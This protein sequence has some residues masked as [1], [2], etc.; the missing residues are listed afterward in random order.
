[1]GLDYR[2]TCLDIDGSIQDYKDCIKQFLENII[3]QCS[4]LI[5]EAEKK[6]L[7]EDYLDDFYKEFESSFEGIRETNEDM[8]KEAD[9]QIGT[10]EEEIL[11]LKCTVDEMNYTIRGLEQKISELEAYES[12][13]NR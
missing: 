12:N 13:F 5:G 6:D 1:M 4:P 11:G 10:Y 8:R 3:M 9:S 2:Y 7:I